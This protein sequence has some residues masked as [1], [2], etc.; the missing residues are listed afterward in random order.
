MTAPFEVLTER[1]LRARGSLK[2]QHYGPEVLPLWVAEMDVVP[3]PEVVEALSVAVRRGDTGYPRTTPD[4]AEA[5]AGFAQRLWGWAPDPGLAVTC[6]DVMTGIRVIVEAVVPPGGPV[7]IPSPVYPPFAS[8][9][10]ELGRRVVPAALTAQ[11]RLDVAG[12]R[13]AL[14]HQSAPGASPAAILLCNPHN[15]TGVA[16]SATELAGLAEVAADAGA[17]VISDEVHGPLT[18]PGTAFTPWHTVADSGFVVTSAAKAYNLAGLKA[19]LVL[20]APSERRR[21]LALP[22]SVRYGASHLGLIGHAAG[23]RSDPA[24][25][26]AVNANIAANHALLVDLVADRLPGVAHQRPEAT[27]LA[28]LDLRSTGLGD[29]PADA[30]L[31]RG[32]VA[33]NPGPTFGPGGE[34]RVRVNVACPA[35]VLTE[36]VDRIASVVAEV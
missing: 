3:P 28:W 30:L 33:L 9:T 10:A 34:G 22:E 19:A 29:N 5:F 13:E 16:H 25:L 14:A 11:G 15:P 1:Q 21:L 20:A 6:A 24:W 7:L 32:R 4:Y 23:Y 18:A 35:A 36:A 8:F 2:W 27:Y 12:I 31:R 17:T 26:D